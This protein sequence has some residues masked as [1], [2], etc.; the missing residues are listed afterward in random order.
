MSFVSLVLFVFR[1]CSLLL[2]VQ[3]LDNFQGSC[4]ALV[5]F[6]AEDIAKERERTQLVGYKSHSLDT[7][8]V[9]FSSLVKPWEFES[10]VPVLTDQF[11]SHRNAFLHHDL[12]G[13]EFES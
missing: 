12:T 6:T 9:D 10:V 7:T 11:Q 1:M 8:W 13:C 3:V 2:V 4:H 5:P